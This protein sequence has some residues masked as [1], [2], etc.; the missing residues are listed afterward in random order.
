MIGVT[1]CAAFSD[2]LLPFGNMQLRFLNVFS[3]LMVHLFLVMK[4]IP[5]S[6][7]AIACYLF[8][9]P[10]KDIMGASRFGQ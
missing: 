10:L 7:W 5:L 1:K 3:G 4:Y 2:G 6:G 8:I 9:R